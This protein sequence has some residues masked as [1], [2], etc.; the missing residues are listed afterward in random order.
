MRTI[1]LQPRALADLHSIAT[2]DRKLFI[3][4]LR[5]F[6]ECASTPFDG[7]GK[8]EALKGQLHSY[9][10]RRVNDEDLIIYEVSATTITIHSLKGHY[11]KQ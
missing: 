7:I 3:R 11:E 4:C 5:I 10:S 1:T 2:Q 6:E 8:P 9:W